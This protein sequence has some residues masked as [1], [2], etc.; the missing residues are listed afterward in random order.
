MNNLTKFILWLVIAI[1]SFVFMPVTSMLVLGFSLLLFAV[2][3]APL[4]PRA[5]KAWREAR[6]DDAAWDALMSEKWDAGDTKRFRDL[7][8]AGWPAMSARGVVAEYNKE[9]ERLLLSTDADVV[10]QYIKDGDLTHRNEQNSR[11][12]IPS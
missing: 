8:A 5:V 7:R 12:Q 6:A 2:L 10:S 9:A 4:I 3:F 1:L 11:G